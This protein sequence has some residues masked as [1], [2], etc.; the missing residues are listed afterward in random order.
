[1]FAFNPKRTSIAPFAMELE[2]ASN[3]IG[4]MRATLFHNPTAGHKATKDD[5]L[6][7]MKLADFDVRYVSV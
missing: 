2:P 5:I 7:A 6:A 3:V 4:G 1:M